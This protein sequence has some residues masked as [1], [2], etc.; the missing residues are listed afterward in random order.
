MWSSYSEFQSAAGITGLPGCPDLFIVASAQAYGM[1]KQRVK[2]QELV[3]L[4]N[5]KLGAFIFPRV[6]FRSVLVPL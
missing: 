3:R 1:V 6:T 4:L 5:G 2:R